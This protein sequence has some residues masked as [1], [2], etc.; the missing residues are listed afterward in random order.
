[1]NEKDLVGAWELV[2]WTSLKNDQTDGYPMGEDA[3]GQIIYSADGR[4]SGF[5]MRTDFQSEP[6]G[7]PARYD[8]SLAYGGTYHIDGDQVVHDVLYATIPHWI[9]GQLRRVFDPQENGDLLLRTEPETSKSG[10]RY[11]HHL[12]WRRVVAA[13][14]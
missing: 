12:L 11:E 9:G 7:I 2:R 3:K 5:L 13:A 8:T 6:R 14:E 4:M 10:S 1:M